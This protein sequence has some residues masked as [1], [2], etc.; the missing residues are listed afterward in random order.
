MSQFIVGKT[1]DFH[2]VAFELAMGNRHGLIAGATGTGK[3]VTLQRLAEA[4]SQAGVSVFTADVKGDLAGMAYPASDNPKLTQRLKDLKINDFTPQG[5]PV[6]LWDIYGKL[7][8]PLRATIS[9][10][11]PLLLGRLMEL[12]D[13]Q[14]G[15]LNA[16]FSIAD[17]QGLLLIDIKDLRAM[18]EWMGANASELQTKY[19]NI[20]A[21]TLG[22]IQRG[23]L[24]LQ[25]AGG[26]I[27]F[28]EPAFKI[29]HLF[30]KDS[31]G[32]GVINILDATTLISDSRLYSTFLLW[33][34][35]ELFE[36]L[37]EAGDLDKPKLV[38]FFDEAHLIFNSAPKPL[39]EKID[40]LVRLIRSKG[41][42]I[43]FI[44]QNP[45]DIPE[46]V[47][48]QLGNR[49]QHALRA[50]TPKDQKAVKAAAQTF[51]K[52]P[53]IDTETVITQLGVGEALVSLLDTNGTPGIV[54]QVKIIPP[55]SRI[56]PITKE[57]RND[58]IQSSN[59]N[60]IYSQSIDR[61]SAFEIL[62]KRKSD[63]STED[64][65]KKSDKTVPHEPK[66]Q[67]QGVTETFLKSTAR[68]VGT[69]LGKQIVRG[70]L[71]SIFGK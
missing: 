7:G 10:M 9:D 40:Q 8:H 30:Q 33:L 71:G 16:S 55:A 5:N 4:F 25:Q 32:H 13:T 17:D 58:L 31:N 57:E 59:L 3:T 53:A 12:N 46:S 65:T 39:L 62:N 49:A 18:L 11:G 70:L 14:Q 38:F 67:R 60:S 42:G 21:A 56:G 6:V 22:A 29:E 45:I 50:F 54:N 52:N 44:S 26:D 34:L 20:A 35:S 19:G 15:V 47:L 48:S 1:P 66:S 68:N 61:E 2:Q 27:F 43:Y 69:Q 63:V 28:G 23:I 36:T 51:R 64:Q 41:I 24:S 37:P